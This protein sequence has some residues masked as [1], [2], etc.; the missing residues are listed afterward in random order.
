MGRVLIGLLD[1]AVATIGTATKG[2]DAHSCAA[3]PTSINDGARETARNAKPP[4]LAALWEVP[5]RSRGL[6]VAKHGTM[7]LAFLGGECVV[8]RQ[9]GAARDRKQRPRGSTSLESL[10]RWSVHDGEWQVHALLR[11]G[12]P[13]PRWTSRRRRRL[14]LAPA[15]PESSPHARPNRFTISEEE[16]ANPGGLRSRGSSGRVA[17]RPSDQP[18]GAHEVELDTR[19]WRPGCYYYRLVVGSN[20]RTQRMVIFQ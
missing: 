16:A 15:V 20:Q 17:D 19:G 11:R 8:L 14:S 2:V 9:Q 1:R 4:P 12:S 13:R 5:N 18:A 10:R 6:V 3:S 7:S